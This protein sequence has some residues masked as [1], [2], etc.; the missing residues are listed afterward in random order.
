MRSAL[1]LLGLAT[2]LNVTL[3]PS[4][5]AQEPRLESRVPE[6]TRSEINAI[7]DSAGAAG[8]PTEPLVD[9]ALEGVAKGADPD[10]ILAAVRRLSGELRLAYDALG[11]RSSAAEI[12]S[13]AS[14]IRAGARSEDLAYLR[15]LRADQPL[16]V[17]AA[18]LAD[19]VAVGVPA[20][21]AIAAV[22]ALAEEADDAH[23]VAFRRNVERDIALGASPVAALGVRLE[24]TAA[25]VFR[26]AGQSP[27]SRP[28]PR[29]P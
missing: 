27:D 17:A 2:A 20:D 3:A 14:A 12:I 8:L 4:G 21:T 7:L 9:R 24:A 6:P 28:R 16:T 10:R 26:S 19:L 23:Y 22:I 11:P 18:T 29:K 5:S 1:A 13:G 15:E 25:D